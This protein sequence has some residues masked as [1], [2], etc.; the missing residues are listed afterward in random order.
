MWLDMDGP[1][2]G[3]RG[4]YNGGGSKKRVEAVVSQSKFHSL[5]AKVLSDNSEANVCGKGQLGISYVDVVR[6]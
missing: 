3:L 5:G 6:G 1:I 2:E 4:M